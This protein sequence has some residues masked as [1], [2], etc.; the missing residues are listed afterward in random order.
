MEEISPPVF[1]ARNASL[2][3]KYGIHGLAV[4]VFCCGQELPLTNPT[5]QRRSRGA[6]M[7]AR[8]ATAI[9]EFYAALVALVWPERKEP[10]EIKPDPAV[11]ARIRKYMSLSMADR[12]GGHGPTS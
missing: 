9:A 6:M 8:K 1:G 3:N 10:T 11:T 5:T 2:R 4:F 12:Y 7:T